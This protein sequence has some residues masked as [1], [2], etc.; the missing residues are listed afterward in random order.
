PA[1]RALREPVER[2]RA[3]AERLAR[4]VGGEVVET[5]ARAGGGSL[6][7]DELPSAAVAL[8]VELAAALRGS[9]PPVVAVVRDDRTL[10]DCRTIADADVDAVAA[11]VLACR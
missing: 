11:A 8:E 10:L 2:V 4:L 3:R 9:D 7:L 1:L 6:P 5:T